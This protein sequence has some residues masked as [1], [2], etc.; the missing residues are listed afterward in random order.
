MQESLRQA[1]E[2]KL[3]INQKAE[4]TMNKM[5]S[6]MSMK[7]DGT[8]QILMKFQDELAA[9][10]QVVVSVQT[11]LKKQKQANSD[12]EAKMAKMLTKHA[13]QVAKLNGK[14]NNNESMVAKYLGV[15]KEMK[16]LKSQIQLKDAEIQKLKMEVDENKERGMTNVDIN[17]ATTDDDLMNFFGDSQPKRQDSQMSDNTYQ[18]DIENLR[19]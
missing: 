5:Q 9:K 15:D 17:K 3:E 11:D 16:N 18:A 2:K 6:E 13:A 14:L 1:S 12:L 4:S 10:D 19:Q 7:E 8:A